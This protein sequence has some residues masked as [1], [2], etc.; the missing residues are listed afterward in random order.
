MTSQTTTQTFG[1]RKN[2]PYVRPQRQFDAGQREIRE[3]ARYTRVAGGARGRVHGPRRRHACQPSGRSEG[4]F[5]RSPPS[6]AAA[7]SPYAAEIF[8]PA[9]GGGGARGGARGGPPRGK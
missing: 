1:A 4:D 8:T 3:P 7:A 5:L 2:W 9:R 6:G